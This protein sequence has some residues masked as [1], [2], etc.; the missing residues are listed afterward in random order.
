MIRVQSKITGLSPL[1]WSRRLADEESAPQKN[2]S[3]HDA[4]ARV[5]RK[6][7]YERNGKLYVPAAAP[8]FAIAHTAKHLG[9]K[10]PGKGGGK[11][12]FTKNF[13]AGVMVTGD[14]FVGKVDDVRPE[15]VWCDSRGQRNGGGSQVQRCFPMLDE[16]SATVDFVVADD[17]ITE[18]I[19]RQVWE[20]TGLLNGFGRFRPQ[21]GGN[22]GMFSVDEL[23]WDTTKG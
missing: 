16:W 2:E 23:R 21:N 12:T 9:L 14:V 5:W 17:D 18:E 13:T 8:K 6:K 1:S 15:W 4:E 22:L 20:K 19:F 11:A 7:Y 3:R 10:V